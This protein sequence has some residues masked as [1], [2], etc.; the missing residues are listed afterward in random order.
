MRRLGERQKQL[1]RLLTQQE[2]FAETF[3][4]AM[5]VRQAT[6]FGEAI[7]IV[8]Y[9]PILTLAGI[10]GKM[11]HPMAMTVILALAGAFVLSLTL[12]PALVALTLRGRIRERE[13]RLVHWAKLAYEPVLRAAVRLRWLVAAIAVAIFALSLWLFSRLGQEFIPKLD[14]GDIAM[15][16]VRITSTSIEQS[17]AMQREVERAVLTLPEVAYVFSKTGT[18]EAAF[19]PMPPSVSDAFIMLKPR[20]DWPDPRLTKPA[21][22]DKLR[23]TVDQVAGNRYVYTQPIELRFNEL[24][25]GV[26]ADLAVKVFG[27]N[28]TDLLLT[29]GD[30]ATV[31]GSLPGASEVSTESVDGLP[32]LAI[33][34][35]RA[36]CARLGLAIADVQEVVASALGGSAAGV[37]FEGDRRFDIVI[38]LPDAVRRDLAALERLPVP[39]PGEEQ[40]ATPLRGA[41]ELAHSDG[42]L[43]GHRFVPLSAVAAIE[44]I[45]GLNQVSREDGKR[46]I[47]VQANIRGRDLGSFVAEAQRRVATE[48]VLPAGTW[49]AWGGQFENLVAAK[50]R[51]TVVVPVCLGLIAI[52]LYMTFGSITHGALV[53]TGV[54]LALTGGILALWLRGMSFSI[55]A[56]VGFIA[57]SGVAVL[58]S[59]VMVACINQ[60][61][62]EGRD[63][64]G[65][66]HEGSMTRLRPVLMTALVASL[67]FVPMALASGQG[68][69]VQK[70]LATVVIGGIVSS[71]LLTLVV[72]PALY[73]IFHRDHGPQD[74]A[75]EPA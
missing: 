16:S 21:L 42:P 27:D 59:L 28:F 63:L 36:A 8:V 43:A 70:P 31:I 9:L 34:V 68:A 56:A 5:Q 66:I 48:V 41:A 38:R 40:D 52:L 22:V 54:P 60:L 32:S 1:G 58:N 55:S 49:I 74:A 20:A 19:D 11:F 14:E 44:V 30:V 25:S 3:A 46:R 71:T 37:V 6:L 15:Q 67:G 64:P 72:L 12:V 18:A 61:R 65:A 50:R 2:R 10:E 69:E 47:V 7:I 17:T 53:F 75:V 45:E 23:A 26:R 29:A 73:R 51:L 39:L 57:L 62:R 35:D 13:T 4:A 24:I 33:T